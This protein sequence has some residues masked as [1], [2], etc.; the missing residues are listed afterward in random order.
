[1]PGGGEAVVGGVRGAGRSPASGVPGG[2]PPGQTPET[3]KPPQRGGEHGDPSGRRDSNPRPSPWQGDALPTEPRPRDI[4]RA[5]D[6]RD[7]PPS[8]VTT[9][10]DRYVGDQSGCAPATVFRPA[11]AARPGGTRL[12]AMRTVTV[13]GDALALEDLVAV[14]RG[15]AD[16]EMGPDVG[17]RMAASRAVVA[18]AGDQDRVMYG[19]TT[20][21]G[22]LAD[23]HVGRQDLGRM[24][25]A[26]IRS[27]SAGVGEPLPDDVVRGLLLLRARTLTAGY[28]GVRLELPAKLLELLA[29]DLLPVIPGK[30]SVGASGDLAQLAHLAQPLVG[31][32]RL[33]RGGDT[34]L[35]GRP[36]A[37]VLAE[38]GVEP[39]VLAP[40]EGLSL[41][42]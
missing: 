6:A 7:G 18:E 10:A 9:I 19:I 11:T 37:E 26:L 40:K 17:E 32:G 23:T 41:I 27:H 4:G 12:P 5:M 1:M 34:D 42:N 16:A 33:R 39:L 13:T 31:E 22:A 21:F 29:H 30:G 28:S 24:Q 35:R 15:Q 36:A 20:G 3:A 2:R 8:C 14:A 38:A 25:L